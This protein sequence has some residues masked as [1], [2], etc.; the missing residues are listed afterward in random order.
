MI[1]FVYY[2]PTKMVFGKDT[3]YEVGKLVKETG[4]KSVLVH[5]G[6][7]RVVRTGLIS[8]VTKAL[9]EEGIKYVVLGGVVPNPHLSKVREGIELGKANNVDLILAVGGGSVIDSSKAIAYGLGEP[10]KDVWELYRHERKALKCLPVA[11]ILT[12]AAAGSEMSNSSVITNEITGEKRAYDDDIARPVFSIL[13]PEFTVTLPDYQTMSGCTDMMMHTM[14]RYFSTAGNMEIT[15]AIAEAL[16]RQVMKTSKI[17]H[18]DPT[19]YEARA[20]A[21]WAGSL[22]H[23]GLTGC[24]T[25]SDWATHLLEHELGGMFDVTHGAGLAAIW[26]SWARYVHDNDMDRF[27]KF[28]LNVME[29]EK[30]PTDEETVEAGIRALENFYHEIGMPINMKELGIEPTDEQIDKL[31]ESCARAAGGPLGCAKPLLKEDMVKIY[32]MA[33]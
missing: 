25:N 30:Q 19:N 10:D 1:N 23:N 15:D 7:E 31:A 27:V 2:T 22:A 24:G 33:R 5:Y 20:D 17:L 21:M 3:Q 8:T 13:N 9:D 29:V 18:K 6:S 16:M 12:I 26:P 4:A 11:T 14:E 28:A 32:K